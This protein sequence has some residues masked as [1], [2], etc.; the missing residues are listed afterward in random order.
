MWENIKT[1]LKPQIERVPALAKYYR[2][3]R[4][5][6]QSGRKP[7]MTP[8]GFKMIGEI[9]MEKGVYEPVETEVFKRLIKRAD[10]F[11]DAG[12]N[13]GYYCC[14]AIYL[15]KPVIA[16]EPI[17]TTANILMNNVMTNGW[18]NKIE[19]FQLALTDKP[20]IINIYGRGPC[21]SIIP[22]W[23]NI[24]HRDARLVPTSSLDVVLG[25]RIK[26]K[27]PLILIDVEGAEYLMLKGS[28]I[29]LQSEPKPIWMIEICISENRTNG[30]NPY[31]MQTFE[32]FWDAGYSSYAIDINNPNKLTLIKRAD[33]IDLFEGRTKASQNFIFTQ[34][35]I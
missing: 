31:F 2:Y 27:R 18:E 21:A 5:K 4:D 19:I 16:F 9:S 32:L 35:A 15:G 14:W 26:G 6:R 8:M 25:D 33:A 34:D 13:V 29:L 28:K 7:I 11:I 3:L 17:S 12:A 22:E 20:G 1:K 23:S 30:K 10:L 24:P